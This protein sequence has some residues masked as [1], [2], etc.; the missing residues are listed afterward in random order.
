M[1]FYDKDIK[2]IDDQ[3]EKAEAVYFEEICRVEE[4]Y[5]GDIILK[6]N[7][8]SLSNLKDTLLK[9]YGAIEIPDFED[10]EYFS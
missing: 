3:I 5:F 7:D 4:F 9:Y 1:H 10:S 6:Q 2:F 8:G